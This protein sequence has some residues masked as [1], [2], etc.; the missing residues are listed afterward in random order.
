MFNTSTPKWFR[1]FLWTTIVI[2]LS[3]VYVGSWLLVI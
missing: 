2:S 3:S 1:I